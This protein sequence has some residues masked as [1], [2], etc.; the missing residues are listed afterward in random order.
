MINPA[1]LVSLAGCVALALFLLIWPLRHHQSSDT[2]DGWGKVVIDR[3]HIAW[4][5]RVMIL[6]V[7]FVVSTA[8]VAIDRDAIAAGYDYL[9]LHLSLWAFPSPAVIAPYARHL[10]PAFRA[11]I[12]MGIVLFG[13]VAPARIDRRMVIILHAVVYLGI[14]V[15]FDSLMLAVAAATRLPIGGYGV[16]GILMNM[17]LGGVVMLHVF[18]TSFQLPRPTRVPAQRGVYRWPTIQLVG[19]GSATLFIYGLLIALLVNS[20]IA[21]HGVMLFIG[22]MTYS[23]LWN[24]LMVVLLIL[25]LVGRRRPVPSN[26]RPPIHVIICAYNENPGI[27]DTLQSIEAA[28][29]T[30]AGPVRVSVADDGSTDGTAALARTVMGEFTAATGDVL[31][32]AHG[33]KSAALNTALAGVMASIVIRIDADVVIAPDAFVYLPGWF[34]DPTVGCVGGGTMPRMGRSWIHRMRLLECLSS[35]YFARVGLMTVDGISCIPGTFQAFRPAPALAVGGYVTG[36]NGEDADLTMLLGRLGYRVIIDTRIR[37][38]EDVPSTVLELQEQRL[39]WYRA[40][41]HVFARQGPLLAGSAGPRVWFNSVRLITLRFLGTLR[42]VLFLYS[43]VMALLHPTSYRN[44]W[45]VFV[46][47]GSSVVPVILVTTVVAI[48]HRY[49]RYLPWFLIWYPT[50]VVLRRAIVIESL[51]TLPTRPVRFRVALRG[52]PIWK[53]GAPAAEPAG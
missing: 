2:G 52:R 16:E 33:G 45:F 21:A 48:R 32:C 49:A 25:G 4:P 36:M 51:L 47:F 24:G 28:A 53:A 40:G 37:V 22:F 44:I 35:F 34:S 41:A 46:L 3:P 12:A 29:V 17:L 11:M 7:L 23:V 10:E 43:A 13:L 6:L 18:F 31:E 27:A 26:D 5:R 14:S 30:Y 15:L 8:L 1:A 50:F 9:V 39:R 20:G 42:P 19:A 38:F